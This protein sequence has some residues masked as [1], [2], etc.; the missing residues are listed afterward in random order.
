MEQSVAVSAS[1]DIV[2]RE[3]VDIDGALKDH[4]LTEVIVNIGECVTGN[5]S[6][7][8]VCLGLGSCVAVTI[9][10]PTAKIAGLAHVMLPS[11]DMSLSDF[12]SNN[13]NKKFADVAI[14]FIVESLLKSGCLKSSL[15]AKITGGAQMFK[16]NSD[17]MLDIGKRNVN[18]VKIQLS[19]FNIPI[20]S[21]NIYG[22]EGRTMRF[23]IN[24]SRMFV[25]TKSKLVKM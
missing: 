3:W 12:E 2:K 8:L 19:N 21:E 6:N 10:D 18:S 1:E 14:P 9:F 25:R 5:S 7:V 24:D 13:L 15:R 11:K 4:L 16:T 17:E 23:I 20:I 22:S